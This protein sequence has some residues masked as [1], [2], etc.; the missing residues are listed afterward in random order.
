MVI[1]RL[2]KNTVSAVWHPWSFWVQM[3]RSGTLELLEH[4]GEPSNE[5]SSS[6]D[7]GYLLVQLDFMHDSALLLGGA[8]T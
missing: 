1:E 8:V 7:R 5:H 3:I 6:I 4:V 2:N